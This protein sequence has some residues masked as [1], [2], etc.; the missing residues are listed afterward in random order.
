MILC[1]TANPCLDKTLAV[2]RWSPGDNVRGTSLREVVGGKGNNVARAL[3]R[4]G[5]PARPATFLGGVMGDLCEALLREDDGFDPLIVPTRSATRVIL[6]VRG[7]DDAATAFFDPDPD[8]AADEAATLVERVESSLGR[9][10]IEALTL[11]GSSP[12]AAT[13]G[14]YAALAGAAKRHGIP[15]FVD[16]YGPAL[17]AFRDAWPDAIQLNRREAAA[18]LRIADP[19]EADLAGLLDSWARS[20]IRSAIVT[21]GP[22][23]VLARV[24]GRSFRVH[25]PRI[26][27]VN[28]IGSGDCLLAG[29][30]DGWLGGLDPAAMLRRAVASATANALTWDA[31]GIDLATVKRLEADV[32]VEEV[33]G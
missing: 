7:P 16:T 23:R 32:M 22:G 3:A 5:R 19:T 14:L 26:E 33:A 13:H 30:V 2:P 15:A 27:A 12:S 9:G 4:L 1:V 11:S 28:P 21:D 31:G 8:I 18:H 10:G 17:A 20:G 6:T 29:C 24:D 25:P